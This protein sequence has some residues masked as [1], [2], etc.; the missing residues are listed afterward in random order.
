MIVLSGD[1]FTCVTLYLR[2]NFEPNLSTL[3]E[4]T[5]IF[6]NF[7]MAAVRHFTILTASFM[8]THVGILRRKIYF[9]YIGHI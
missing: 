6:P 2:V 7:M 3:F 4:V 5:A 1:P 8:I 9:E